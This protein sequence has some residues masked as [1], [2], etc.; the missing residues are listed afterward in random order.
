MQ[1]VITCHLAASRV[2][3]DSATYVCAVKSPRI[4]VQR[5]I[6]RARQTRVPVQHAKDRW[7]LQHMFPATIAVS[8]ARW[9]AAAAGRPSSNISNTSS[10]QHQQ[11]PQQQ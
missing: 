9:Q 2:L 5:A 4:Y 3:A 11:Q 1:Y 7:H 10:Q 6:A 8:G